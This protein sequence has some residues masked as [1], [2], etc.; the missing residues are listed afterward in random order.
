[1]N[2][3]SAYGQNF[4]FAA[5]GTWHLLDEVYHVTHIKSAQ[6]IVQDGMIKR[7][8]VYDESRLNTT[9]TTVNWVSPNFWH[10][11]FRYGTVK[12]SYNWASLAFTKNI[13]WVEAMTGYSPHACRF[14]ISNVK[15]DNTLPYLMPYDSINGDGPLRRIGKDWYWNTKYT[16]E[17]MLDED[18][19]LADCT[20]LDFVD[21]H[22][23]F[24]NER[25]VDC[26]EKKFSTQ[27]A[28]A[29]M[30]AFII[31]SGH[32]VLDHCLI[33]PARPSHLKTQIEGGLAYLWLPLS[34]NAKY[35]GIITQTGDAREILQNSLV[36]YGNQMDAR[37]K[38][39]CELLS[40]EPQ[41][42]QALTDLIASHFGFSSFKFP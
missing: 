9:R 24:C 34:I 22:K 29:Y 26:P 32:N 39:L 28:G 31:G 41:F 5:S 37:A 35:K 33:D 38:K 7:G 17:I 1:M 4:P 8:L 11:G 18:L 21:H 15:L 16:L 10:N 14:I 19:N 36:L 6:R 2:P 42:E 23:D 12:F 30:M 13:Y 20:N 3:W 27:K 25:R 40:G